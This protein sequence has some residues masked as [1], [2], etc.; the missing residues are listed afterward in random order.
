MQSKET[1]GG[2]GSLCC[3][4]VGGSLEVGGLNM[5]L[6]HTAWHI[7]LIS[8]RTDASGPKQTHT[9]PERTTAELKKHSK[10]VIWLLNTLLSCGG[11]WKM[12]YRFVLLIG[13]ACCFSLK[14]NPVPLG[15]KISK[16][17][18]NCVELLLCVIFH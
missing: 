10:Y 14:P 4:C 17:I 18:L 5:L 6:S 7:A 16:L 13:K 12:T 15:C 1:N 9:H 8:S 11:R 3:C 2:K